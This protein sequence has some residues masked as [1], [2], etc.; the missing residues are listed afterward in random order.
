MPI[1]LPASTPTEGEP[2]VAPESSMTRIRSGILAAAVRVFRRTARLGAVGGLA[3]IIGGC[4]LRS[5]ASDPP[6][7]EPDPPDDAPFEWDAE[8]F[9]DLPNPPAGANSIL[10]DGESL[11]VEG[12]LA[13]AVA[14]F[15]RYLALDAPP[16]GTARAHWGLVL[17]RITPDTEIHDPE[18][19]RRHL[20]ALVEEHPGTVQGLQARWLHGLMV[21]LDRSRTAA[22][23][24]AR[25]V[26]QLTDMVDRL[27]RIDLNRR[28]VPRPD[29]VPGPG[30]H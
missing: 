7:P 29:S 24:Q 13:A 21:E 8:N 11:L 30:N 1:I 12:S 2:G 17:A 16:E 19:A 26:E 23:E 15:E 25:L 14:T 5:G 18:E 9:L 22:T 10:R 27:R 4:G 28:P 3:L 6:T 20:E